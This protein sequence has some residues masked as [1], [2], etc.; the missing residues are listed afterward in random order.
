VGSGRHLAAALGATAVLA[1][2]GASIS[3]TTR[4]SGA[5]PA[6]C[7]TIAVSPKILT[8]DGDPDM[9]RV[10]VTA[11][12]KPVPGARVQVRGVGVRKT[13]RT[14]LKGVAV[15]RVN[16]QRR[17]SITITVLDTEDVCTGP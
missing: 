2:V 9:L 16:P 17:G 12:G 14:N 6:A 3:G 13:G 5:N 10:K 1:L 7:P 15:L 4:A 11:R 8:A